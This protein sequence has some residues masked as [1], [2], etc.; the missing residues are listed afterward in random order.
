MN[1]EI[2]REYDIRGIAETDLKTEDMELIGKAYGTLIHN[3][4]GSTVIVGNDNRESGPR[5]LEAL[6]KG[7]L[8]TGINIT[9]IG[10]IPTPL[11]YYAVHKLDLDGGISVTAS[12]NP[13][14]FNGFKVMIGKDAIFGEKIRELGKLAEAGNFVKGEGNYSEKSLDETYL[15]EIVSIVNISRKPKFVIDAGNG[16]ASEI[17]PKLFEML[18]LNPTCLFCE[19]DSRFPNH[20]ADPTQEKNMKD[21]REKVLEEKA[22]FGIA[23]DGDVDRIGIV[24][25]KGEMVFGDKLL[26]VFAKDVLERHP[27][28]KVIFE[29]KCSQALEEWIRDNGGVPIMWK[30]G[31]SLIKAKMKE[32]N[33][34]LAGEM[35]GHMFFTENWYGF[36]DALLAA[37]RL[38]E[39]LSK[40][41]KKVSEIIN[42]MPTYVAS[43]ELRIDCAD[44]KK[45]GIVKEMTDKYKEK[46]PE[47][48]TIDGIRIK[49]ENGW[50]LV[51][52]SNTQPKIILR[53]EAK[54]KEELDKITN[55][56]KPEVEALIESK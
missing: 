10:E 13:P 35:S 53:F 14:E 36:D 7:I 19:K 48:V 31:H 39:I 56:I 27:N 45:E 26:G 55:L 4:G 2:F 22:E 40:T 21:L 16:M 5:I 8:S 30:T 12:H 42:E 50:A 24:D 51:R 41:E 1:Q 6:K 46:Y 47:S 28:G 15:K 3:N 9:Y 25:E 37:V 38:I 32:E 44:D 49:M 54:N 11:L 20:I 33:A 23:F 29:V 43:P 17:A 18:G 34:V 52:K